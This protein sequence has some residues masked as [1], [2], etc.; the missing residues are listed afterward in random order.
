MVFNSVKRE[1]YEKVVKANN[2]LRVKMEK[3]RLRNALLK[4]QIRALS[5]LPPELGSLYIFIQLKLNVTLE[6]IQNSPKFSSMDEENIKEGLEGLM[7]RGL[8]EK[9]EKE[10]RGYYSVKTPEFS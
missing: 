2:E 4:D 6:D 1:E 8:V 9:T 10:G 7:K 3:L 5:T